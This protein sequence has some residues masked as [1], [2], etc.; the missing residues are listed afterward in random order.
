MT[1]AAVS[2]R[3]PGARPRVDG[4][5]QDVVQLRAE[6]E[7]L[8]RAVVSHAVVDHAIGVLVAIGRISPRAGFTVL[9]EVSQH[10]NTKL[11]LIAE[12]IITCTQ[13]AALPGMILA[14]LHAAFA[15]RR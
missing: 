3:Q 5:A 14:E 1:S 2:A 6:N 8:Q 7:Q 13:A 12:Q 4:L 15:R 11:S 10:T 9:R